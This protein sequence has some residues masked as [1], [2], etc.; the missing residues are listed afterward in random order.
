MKQN[1]KSSTQKPK[2]S[3]KSAK[4]SAQSVK[5][6]TKKVQIKTAVKN[7][8]QYAYLAKDVL[9][10]NA[11]LRPDMLP[12]TPW[13][14]PISS[15]QRSTIQEPNEFQMQFLRIIRNCELRSML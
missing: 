8:A 5:R 9:D 3:N 7:A 4:P 12:I 2:N 1:T 13:Q 6:G 15:Y 11:I 14:K 10:V